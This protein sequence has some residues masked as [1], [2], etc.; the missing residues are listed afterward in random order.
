MG[1]WC[2][3]FVVGCS[4]SDK[5][6]QKGIPFGDGFWGYMYG[7]YRVIS[8]VGPGVFSFPDKGHHFGEAEGLS[9]FQS[10]DHGSYLLA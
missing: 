7:A 6:R 2:R 9:R 3:F 4:L 1:L 8:Q 5:G 10:Y